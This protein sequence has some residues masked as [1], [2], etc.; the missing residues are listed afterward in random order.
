MWSP[1]MWLLLIECIEDG[2]A[3]GEAIMWLLLFIE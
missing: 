2:L 1:L 3:F